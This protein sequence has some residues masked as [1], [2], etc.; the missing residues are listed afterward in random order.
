MTT[1]RCTTTA[2]ALTLILAMGALAW[3]QSPS[4]PSPRRRAEIATTLSKR[5]ARQESDRAAR[6]A[7]AAGARADAAVRGAHAEI[8]APVWA[9]EARRNMDVL[10]RA[11][12]AAT[13]SR[14][15]NVAEYQAALER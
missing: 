5:H 1:R 9:E 12:N 6:A 8:M 13:Y 14:F 4:E 15:A 3:G 10:I 7:Q 11:Q 2:L